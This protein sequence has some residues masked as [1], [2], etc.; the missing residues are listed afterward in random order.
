MLQS[1][2]ETKAIILNNPSNPTGMVYTKEELQA[3]ADVCVA[4]DIYIIADEIYYCLVYDNKPFTSIAA[5]R[6]R[7]SAYDLGQWCFQSLC[8]D[9]LAHRLHGRACPGHKTDQQLSEPF[10]RCAQYD[11]PRLRQRSFPW[12]PG[13][14]Q[15]DARGFRGPPQ[16]HGGTHECDRFHQLSQ[17]TG[18]HFTL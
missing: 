6:R 4:R 11:L 17:T 10:H 7:Q 12:K 13:K 9:W 15:A 1:Q 5:G 2:T 8:H 3:L 18:A 14:R 16:L